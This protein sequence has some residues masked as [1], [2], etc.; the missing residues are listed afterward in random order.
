V[1]GTERSR[2]TK[3]T[4]S[5]A[6]SRP[7]PL[8]VSRQLRAS[9]TRF[10]A[11][12]DA[13]P[14]PMAITSLAEGRYLEINDAFVKQIGFDRAEIYGRTSLEIDVWPTP[15]DRVAM[16]TALRE[17]QTLRNRETRFRTKSGRLITTLYS[18]TL[19][20]L[21]GQPC[22][23]AAIE[24][25]TLQR[26]AEDALRQSEANFRLLAETSPCC[27]FIYRVDGR[28]CYVNPQM[29]ITS[30]YSAE[31]LGGMSAWDLVHPEFQAFVRALTEA[32]FRGE[33]LPS[34]C[35]LQTVA[36][37][38]GTR[39]L[40][41]AA[42]P[43]AFDGSPAILGMAF[44]ITTSKYHEEQIKE[45]TAFLQTLLES[46]PFAIIVGGPDGRVRFSNQAFQRLFQY[47]VGEVVGRDPDD[48]VGVPNDPEAVALSQRVMSG[49]TVH[50]TTVRRRKDGT[51]VDV[52]LHASPLMLGGTFAGCFWIYQD[53]TERVESAAKLRTLR[54]RLT[55]V[56][57]EERA[58]VA[59][60][61][62]DHTSQRL[63]LL[64][65]R[66]AE[67]K[68]NCGDAAPSIAGPLD[69]AI[70]LVD[71]IAVDLHRLSRRLHPSQ[72]E[73]IGLT[74]ALLNLCEEYTRQSGMTIELASANVPDTLPPDV[75]ICLYR[76][77][78]E[79]IRNAVKHSGAARVQLDLSTNGDNIRLCVQDE[80]RGFAGST[81]EG[82]VGLGLVSMAERIGSIGGS[83]SV[84]S[85]I[86]RGTRIEASVPLAPAPLMNSSGSER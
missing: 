74:P 69:S 63:A 67:L 52:E 15:A 71:E 23:L 18:A 58:H 56:Q 73:Y 12:F 33:D 85:E 72:L 46:S 10:A 76:V 24:D 22:V 53:I 43:I 51:R 29:T 26:L 80:G 55:R 66:L 38:G 30:G 60:E 21:D 6:P 41:F 19:I 48:L 86:D 79:A 25:I 57:D 78:Q 28:F 27:I 82:G 68:R 32:R 37:D 62:H 47:A 39:W 14:I 8:S 20:E 4:S 5:A 35:E 44:D 83:W 70:G 40:D 9:E 54:S 59:R 81:C 16:V 75:V 2:R 65:L 31:E 1:D 34:R 61:L 11:A 13:S 84:T 7:D 17:Q 45:R 49:Q 50:R 77:A 3:R 64:A 36:K 42:A